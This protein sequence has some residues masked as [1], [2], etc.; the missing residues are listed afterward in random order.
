MHCP[1]ISALYLSLVDDIFPPKLI[2]FHW[3][4]QYFSQQEK[5]KGKN[6]YCAENTVQMYWIV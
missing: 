6:V 5:K 1:N 3:I 4:N 2:S